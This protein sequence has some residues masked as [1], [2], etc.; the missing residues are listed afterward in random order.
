MMRFIYLQ[1]ARQ[2]KKRAASVGSVG[3]APL[4]DPI[5]DEGDS[6]TS[7]NEDEEIEESL[8]AMDIVR[9]SL[10]DQVDLESER[11]EDN[12]APPSQQAWS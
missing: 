3:E 9:S 10:E 1:K 8:N 5:K 2:N 12:G 4:E 6:E 7:E 11:T